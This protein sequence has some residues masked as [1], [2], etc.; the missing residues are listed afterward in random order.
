[1]FENLVWQRDRMLL[2]DLVFRLELSRDDSWE[3]GD[4]CFS[5]YKDEGLIAQYETLF[6]ARPN[7]QAKKII[8]LGVW[9][10][11]SMALW[12]E[13][14]Y[15]EKLIGIDVREREDSAYFADYVRRRGLSGKVKTFWGVS[16]SDV[17]TVGKLVESEFDGPIDLIIDDASHLYEPTKASF[18][19]L[20]PLLR[21][22]GLYI[23]EDWAWGHWEEHNRLDHPYF[24]S[25]VELTR[26]VVEITEMIGSGRGTQPAVLTVY[27]GMVV[28]ERGDL[29]VNGDGRFLLSDHIVRRTRAT[30]AAPPPV[31]TLDPRQ[32]TVSARAAGRGTVQLK[33]QGDDSGEEEWLETLIKSVRRQVVDGRRLPGFPDEEIQ[34]HTGGTA[35]EAALRHAYPFYLKLKR[36]ASEL[37]I[38]LG[39]KTRILDFG[40]AW[41]RH[42]R[43]FLKDVLPENLYGSDI[44][45]TFI[46][47]ARRNFPL[48]HFTSNDKLPPLI[49]PDAHFDIIYSYS[50]FSHLNEEYHRCWMAELARVLKPGGMLVVTTQG[51]E[52]I[53]F[54]ASLAGRDEFEHEWFRL[55]ATLF[56]DRQAAE[57]AR[58]DYDAGKFLFYNHGGGGGPR[59]G[60]FYGEAIVP[61]QFFEKEW[62]PYFRLVDF[63]DPRQGA[64]QSEVVAQRL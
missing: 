6:A 20:F 33:K 47:W 43:F 49:F 54:C 11:G 1:M 37:G 13:V 15:P 51:R 50:V 3:L 17:L 34:L 32:S 21:P 57:A 23:I 14:F 9:D 42:L 29:K 4:A 27:P 60:E 62:S 35:G 45:A 2:K 36:C 56:P 40:C 12:S 61:R 25:S 7:F 48:S 16:Q 30:G 22:G 19:A 58:A 38:A 5:F 63:D 10:G 31:R 52:F 46:D 8:E 24:G 39:A 28:V 18:Q 41:G 44:D 55:L 59:D 53:E 64:Q 26:L